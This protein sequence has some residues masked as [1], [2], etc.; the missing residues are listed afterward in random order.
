KA[1]VSRGLKTA[2]ASGPRRKTSWRSTWAAAPSRHRLT[3]TGSLLWND[4]RRSKGQRTHGYWR[5][6]PIKYYTG[7]MIRSAAII[8]LSSARSAET[9]S[10]FFT[11]R[12]ISRY[13]IGVELVA[14]SFH[15]GNLWV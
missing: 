12:N 7:W 3:K 13:V 8:A 4:R 1:T 2:C 11:A 10:L 14:G 15:S 5:H 6:R 9:S